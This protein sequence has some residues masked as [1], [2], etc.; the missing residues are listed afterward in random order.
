MKKVLW[1]LAMTLVFSGS[2]CFAAPPPPAGGMGGRPLPPPPPMIRP[3]PIYR[4]YYTSFYPSIY[5]S[6]YTYTPY[7]YDRVETVIPTTSTVVVRDNY[8]GINT[9]ANVINTAANVAATIR[10]LTW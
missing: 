3:M 10:Y 7:V 2:A 8:A 6:S 1:I 4:P 5:Y 9:A